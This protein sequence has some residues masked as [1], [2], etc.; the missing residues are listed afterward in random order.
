MF[1]LY[2]ATNILS[3]TNDE[4]LGLCAFLFASIYD[5]TAASKKM[6]SIFEVR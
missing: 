4:E 2:I 1:G 3:Y 6:A 5:K